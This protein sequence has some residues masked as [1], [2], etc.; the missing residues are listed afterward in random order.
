MDVMGAFGNK[1]RDSEPRPLPGSTWSLDVC[2]SY[3][4]TMTRYL[5]GSNLSEE[6]LAYLQLSQMVTASS[7]GKQ[8]EMDAGG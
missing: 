3:F 4:L 5:T 1:S 7:T 8:K 2:I 6:G